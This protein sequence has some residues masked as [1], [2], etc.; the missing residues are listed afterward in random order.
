MCCPR[1]LKSNGPIRVEHE[2]MLQVA[3]MSRHKGL[4]KAEEVNFMANF[5][6]LTSLLAAKTR[7]WNEIY[8]NWALWNCYFYC[9]SGLFLLKRKRL[10]SD[11]WPVM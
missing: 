5:S 10:W 11:V 4:R 9:N 6:F 7:I 1:V 8:Y 2:I 3:V